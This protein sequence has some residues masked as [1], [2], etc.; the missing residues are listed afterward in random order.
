[1]RF[2]K[3]PLEGAYRIE[4]DKRGDDRGVFARV[5]W[6][7]EFGAGGLETRFVQAN[8]SLTLKK[9]ALRGLHYQSPPAAEVKV[10]RAIRGALWDVIVDLRP[11]SPTYLKWFGIELPEDNRSMLYIPRGFAHGF[12]TLTDSVE[13]FY[14]DGAFSP[15][16]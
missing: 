14:L 11:G 9:G 8:Y 1:M 4:L 13:A 15:A 16:G 5:F 3:T 6:E 7:N 2:Q 12:I 10:V